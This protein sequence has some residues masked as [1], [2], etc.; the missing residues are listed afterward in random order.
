MK[1]DG[2][3]QGLGLGNLKK[4]IIFSI[5]LIFLA[6]SIILFLSAKP[7]DKIVYVSEV[8]PKLPIML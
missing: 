5:I 3:I 8:L 1:M 4:I 6:S 2:K 7:A